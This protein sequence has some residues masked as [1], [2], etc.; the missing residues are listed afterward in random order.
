[1]NPLYKNEKDVLPYSISLLIGFSN[2]FYSKNTLSKKYKNIDLDRDSTGPLEHTFGRSRIKC[3]NIHTIEKF[4]KT[5]G[6]IN[7]QS[8]SKISVYIEKVKGRSLNFG[9]IIEDITSAP[10]QI[11]HEF[12][13]LVGISPENQNEKK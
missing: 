2:S 6:E 8:L 4:T 10:Q 11:A 1:M 7:E 3:K 5:V 12:L 13:S 9:V